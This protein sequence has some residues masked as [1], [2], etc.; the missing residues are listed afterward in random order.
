M[1]PGKQVL[2]DNPFIVTP[3]RPSHYAA[4]FR[5][6]SRPYALSKLVTLNSRSQ[7]AVLQHTAASTKTVYLRKCTFQMESVSLAGIY[8]IDLHHTI[9]TAVTGNPA[10]TPAPIRRGPTSEATAL[11]LPTTPGNDL[12]ANTLLVSREFNLGATTATV[13]TTNPPV[14]LNEVVLFEYQGEGQEPPTLRAGTLEGFAVTVDANIQST[15]KCFVR[16]E[17]W[18]E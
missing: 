18:E 17:F 16:M 14:A 5:L 12:G 10:I 9:S 13:P 4:V 2:V 7:F 11:A 1:I 8:V 6:A 3:K 15:V